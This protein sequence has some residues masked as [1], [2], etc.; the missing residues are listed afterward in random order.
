MISGTYGDDASESR[1]VSA[2][3]S[4]CLSTNSATSAEYRL[5]SLG[6]DDSWG[7]C[8]STTTGKSYTRPRAD[9]GITDDVQECLVI[10]RHFCEGILLLSYSQMAPGSCRYRVRSPRDVDKELPDSQR[11]A[12]IR[13]GYRTWSE[14]ASA[15]CGLRVACATSFP[16]NQAGV[17][18]HHQKLTNRRITGHG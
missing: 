16:A 2:I 12:F 7:G 10:C 13:W 15:S 18:L 11:S 1:M 5:T 17:S 4:T 3:C 8:Q 14:W 6:M 9:E